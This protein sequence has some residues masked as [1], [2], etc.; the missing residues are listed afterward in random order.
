MF[1]GHYL[2]LI[3]AIV[4]GILAGSIFNGAVSALAL[5][6][7]PLPDGVNWG[8]I[9]AVEHYLANLPVM[10]YV[11]ILIAHVG[12]SFVGSLAG[13]SIGKSFEMY[14][15]IVIGTF[16]LIGGITN[17]ISLPLP[18]WMWVEVPL[19]IVAAY[20]AARLVMSQRAART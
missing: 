19:Y 15:A 10:A 20:A 11:I 3:L 14:V 9:E 6:L 4:A 18:P 17:M 7:Y 1:K 2:R 16:S 8:D 5:R 13:A 12:Q